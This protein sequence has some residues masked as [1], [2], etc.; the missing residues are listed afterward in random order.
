MQQDKK[1]FL[2]G[3]NILERVA[4]QIRCSKIQRSIRM[5]AMKSF[6]KDNSTELATFFNFIVEINL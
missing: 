2:I 5:K 6:C 3:L 1:H 4:E